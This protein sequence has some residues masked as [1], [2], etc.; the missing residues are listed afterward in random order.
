MK[1]AVRMKRSFIRQAIHQACFLGMLAI[2]L[3]ASRAIIL[4]GINLKTKP[5]L[6]DERSYEEGKKLVCFGS[7]LQARI[8]PALKKY[9]PESCFSTSFCNY[10]HF[11]KINFFFLKIRPRKHTLFYSLLFKIRSREHSP[12]PGMSN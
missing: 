1:E 10:P 12:V 5:G 7:F 3:I 6:F 9:G 8:F 2:V 4:Y 11:W